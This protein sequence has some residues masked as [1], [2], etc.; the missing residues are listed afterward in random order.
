MGYLSDFDEQLKGLYGPDYFQAYVDDKAREIWYQAEYERIAKMKPDGGS[1]LDVGCGTGGFLQHF[2]STKWS[3]YGVDVSDVAVEQAR[4]HS[5]TIRDYALGYDYPDESFDVIVFRG[6]IQHL[7]TPFAVIKKC[8]SLLK[9]GGL[10]AFLSTP[11]SNCIYYKLF[12]GLPFLN[13]KF[14]FLIPSDAILKQALTNFGL[15]IVE[16]RYPYLETPYARPLRDHIF[17]F[18]RCLGLRVQFPF[19]R[20]IVEVYA[21]KPV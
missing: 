7:D 3:K 9:Q 14:N 13:P 5:I 19:W 20:N 6:T 4:R 21:L 17:F 1:I 2:D 12:G 16:V 10:M 8:T 18:L 15:E 11:N